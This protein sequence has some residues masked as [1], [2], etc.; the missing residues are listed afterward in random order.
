ML[1]GLLTLTLNAMTMPFVVLS[2]VTAITTAVL[3]TDEQ[4]NLQPIR[5]K[6]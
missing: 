3:S 4:V 5:I 1:N 2:I 6:E